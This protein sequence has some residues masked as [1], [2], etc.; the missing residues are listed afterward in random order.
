MVMLLLNHKYAL[1][2][3]G[4][5]CFG[6]GATLGTF[7]FLQLQEPPNVWEWDMHTL[8]GKRPL[9]HVQRCLQP[10]PE[11]NVV[12]E[13]SHTS[14]SAYY[15]TSGKHQAAIHV[16]LMLFRRSYPYAPLSLFYD[17]SGAELEFMQT[18]A[19]TYEANLSYTK[20]GAH[21]NGAFKGT[22]FKVD[23]AKEY[24]QRLYDAAAYGATW[25]MLLEDDAWVCQ[26]V[27]LERLHYDM[28]GVCQ[29]MG[30][31]LAPFLRPLYGEERT[32]CYGGA[33]G[34]ILRTS[35]LLKRPYHNNE[36]GAFLD[37]LFEKATTT[38]R[39]YLA[40]DEILSAVV[41]YVGGTIGRMY[42]YADGMRDQ[43]KPLMVRHQ[44][45]QLYT[46]TYA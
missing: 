37:V 9:C 23:T 35:S 21:P 41:V 28:N 22:Y 25:L 20:M 36:T 6:F 38:T 19:H 44:M 26:P 45:K 1:W 18:V 46:T 16:V 13:L 40:S 33:G 30:P 8:L 27:H 17:G 43:T 11:Q 2:G 3:I 4:C 34:T 15:Q 42:G 29:H 32:R 31:P 7:F 10:N 24:V 39:E 5:L 12:P 14:M